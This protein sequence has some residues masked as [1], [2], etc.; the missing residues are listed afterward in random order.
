MLKFLFLLVLG[1]FAKRPRGGRDHSRRPWSRPSRP[2]YCSRRS[3][4]VTDTLRE[5][6]LSRMAQGFYEGEATSYCYVWFMESEWPHLEED[7]ATEAPTDAPLLRRN[8]HRG[9]GRG[10]GK[11]RGTPKPAAKF[12]VTNGLFSKDT[13]VRS[14]G[15]FT[16]YNAN[17]LEFLLS[18]L[19]E[20]WSATEE[21][22]TDAP[23]SLSSWSRRGKDK[24]KLEMTISQ[25]EEITMDVVNCMAPIVQDPDVT[26]TESCIA[27]EMTCGG[28]YTYKGDEG[29]AETAHLRM[30]CMTEDWTP[31]G[32][33]DA[34]ACP[35]A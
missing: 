32:W 13:L 19:Q 22:A 4:A 10:E 29:T 1:V 24:T 18:D 26:D 16:C 35:E 27:T 5:N 20:S 8:L 23:E 6:E 33:T 12:S 28:S 31:R 9:G 21:P 11:E 7:S 34:P 2:R 3:A 14:D 17:T 30:K 15:E 25:N